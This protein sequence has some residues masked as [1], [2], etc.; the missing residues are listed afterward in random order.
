MSS[1]KRFLHLEGH[2]KDR[3]PS[4]PRRKDGPSRFSALENPAPDASDGAASPAGTRQ[5]FERQVTDQPLA[6]AERAPE[7]QPFIRCMA[8]HAD[9]SR[10][11]QSCINC[12]E[13]LQTPAQ[14]EFNRALWEERLQQRA[15]EA[16]ASQARAAA[17]REAMAERLFQSELERAR[18]ERE[19]GREGQ[20]VPPGIWLLRRIRDP[21]WRIGVI[22][23]GALT[24]VIVLGAALRGSSGARLALF[25]G[26]LLALVMFTPPRVWLQR[27]RRRWW[28]RDDDY[29]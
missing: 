11:A 3:G 2:R 4:A 6:T 12:S 8:C 9:N 18:L 15:E 7:E 29:F 17:E 20:D 24:F 26:G 21:R 1:L 23:G 19:Y 5:R 13:A 28:E 22:A 16:R 27:R 14:Q 10:Y 25:F